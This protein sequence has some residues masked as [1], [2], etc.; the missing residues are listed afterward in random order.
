M[1]IAIVF[2]FVDDFTEANNVNYPK[3]EA[4][5]LFADS[6][7]ILNKIGGIG[8]FEAF[9]G[10]PFFPKNEVVPLT[11]MQVNQ[12]LME[13]IQKL[14][15]AI[16]LDSS[17]KEI[18]HFMGVAYI[19]LKQLDEAIKALEMA[20]NVKPQK[21][22]SYSFLCFI[23]W[24]KQ[25]FDK[26]HKV[27]GKFLKQYEEDQI[28]GLKLVGS[29]F[30]FQGDYENAIEKGKEII[31]IDDKDIDGHLLLAKSYHSLGEKKDAAN[32]FEKIIK[33]NPNFTEIP[34][35]YLKD[36]VDAIRND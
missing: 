20:I 3:N 1:N 10:R 8:A 7:S 15:K 34:T 17:L 9:D 35:G 18:Y 28:T 14:K 30:Y 33:L 31:N 6:I 11:A 27:A 16:K 5:L 32:E 19:L 36:S 25:R 22:I 13:A 24:H 12:L 2:F 26:A 21:K 23:L 29:T 4:K